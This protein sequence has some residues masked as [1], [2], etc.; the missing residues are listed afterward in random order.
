LLFSY[1]GIAWATNSKSK[2]VRLIE[3]WPQR[4]GTSNNPNSAKVPTLISPSDSSQWGFAAPDGAHEW[5][6]ILLDPDHFHIKELGELS[7]FE[8]TE[9]SAREAERDSQAFLRQLWLHAKERISDALPKYNIFQNYDIK[10]VITVP[11]VWSDTAKERTRQIAIQA[12]LPLDLAIINEP[13]AAAIAVFR[14]L[15]E[16]D[17]VQFKVYS[18]SS[19]L[20]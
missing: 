11:A 17:K 12:G 20:Q 6:K 8:I 7:K 13:E 3:E 1:S 10:A 9:A 2:E 4:E 15:Q 19:A 18:P 16:R 5:F 14:D